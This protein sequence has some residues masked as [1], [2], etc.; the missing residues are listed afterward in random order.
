MRYRKFRVNYLIESLGKLLIESLRKNAYRES[1]EKC[2]K[3]FPM[4]CHITPPASSLAQSGA[5]PPA[6]TPDCAR[7]ASLFF[8][9]TT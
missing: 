8:Y 2:E 5:L 1:R 3:N 4:C 6:T 7:P 9:T